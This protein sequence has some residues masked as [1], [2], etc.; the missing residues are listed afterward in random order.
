M[1]CAIRPAAA[2]GGTEHR[3]LNTSP[4]SMNTPS[5]PWKQSLQR[6]AE[7]LAEISKPHRWS[8]ASS[9]RLEETVVLGCYAVQRLIDA[10]LL[11]HSLVHRL[12]PMTAFLSRRPE[13]PMLGDEPIEVLYDL[14]AGRDVHHDLVFLCHQVLHNVLFAPR[15]DS[16]KA[17]EG[18]YVTSDR[19]R[20]VALYGVSSEIF[21]GLFLEVACDR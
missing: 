10:S 12:V 18:V 15:F 19:Q 16:A 20:R 17:L 3:T 1:D 5:H 7:A 2:G 21:R 8:D 13:R 9:V 11:S 6:Q 4:L 14:Q